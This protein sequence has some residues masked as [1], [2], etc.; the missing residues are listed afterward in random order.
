MTVVG[1]FW[2]LRCI[3]GIYIPGASLDNANA[4][5]LP[6]V[7]ACMPALEDRRDTLSCDAQLEQ[8]GGVR[9]L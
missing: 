5:L 1:H 9:G 6:G 4:G 2:R 8:L 7:A 3:P